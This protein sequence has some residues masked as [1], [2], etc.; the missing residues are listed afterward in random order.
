MSIFDFTL[1]FTGPDAQTDERLDALFEAGCDDATFG[2]RENIQFAD[3]SREAETMAEA[4][5]TAVETLERTVEGVQ[6][7]RIEPEELVSPAVIG[8]R[9]SRSDQSITYLYAGVRGPGDFPSPAAWVDARKKLWRWSEVV[10]W[11][12]VKKGIEFDVTG[13]VE[14]IALFNSIL[15]IRLHAKRLQNDKERRVLKE[16]VEKDTELHNLLTV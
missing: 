11:F 8:A 13:S 1:L 4:I 5:A 2:S 3:F 14:A 6:V 9:T 15:D 16:F 12:R 7:F 10:S